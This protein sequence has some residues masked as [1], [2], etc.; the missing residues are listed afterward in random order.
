MATD[1]NE[2]PRR[3]IPI[4][5]I[6]KL[7]LRIEKIGNCNYSAYEMRFGETLM[8]FKCTKALNFGMRASKVYHRGA[9]F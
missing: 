2:N 5:C 3:D 8:I 6:S 7:T 1:R 4:K 9:L